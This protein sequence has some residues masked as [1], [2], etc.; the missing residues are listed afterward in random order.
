MVASKP[1]TPSKTDRRKL[2]LAPIGFRTSARSSGSPA[3]EHPT[4]QRNSSGNQAGRG[5]R[6]AGTTHPPVPTTEASS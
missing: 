4:T 6:Q 2:M 3:Y 1:P 5:A